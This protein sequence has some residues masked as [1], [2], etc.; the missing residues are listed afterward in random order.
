MS[1]GEKTT[2]VCLRLHFW[3]LAKY[4]KTGFFLLCRESGDFCSAGV[5]EMRRRVFWCCHITWKTGS[6]SAES[7]L[8][9]CSGS[10][11]SHFTFPSL[12]PSCFLRSLFQRASKTSGRRPHALHLCCLPTGSGFRVFDVALLL[13]MLL[14]FVCVFFNSPLLEWIHK[15]TWL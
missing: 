2:L 10:D 15:T 7:V 11:D 5:Y 12:P 8:P 4:K 3:L 14:L 1:L 9:G 13:L 6:A